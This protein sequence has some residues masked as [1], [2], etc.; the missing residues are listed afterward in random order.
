AREAGDARVLPYVLRDYFHATW[1]ADTLANRRRCASEMAE[2]AERIDDPLARIWALDRSVHVAIEAGRMG[3]AEEA[4][5]QLLALTEE[6]GQP[7]L[8]WHA[9][10]FASGLA[11]QRGALAEAGRL[12]EEAAKLGERAGE[13][14][15][16]MIYFGQLCAIRVA[17][18]RA[19][20]IVGILEGATEANPGI[21]GFEAALAAV[22]CDVERDAEAAPRLERAAQAGFADVPRDQVYLTA[23]ALWARTAADVGSQ[24]AAGPLYELIEPWRD[25]LVWNGASGYGSA[26]AYLGMLASTLGS[27][28]RAHEHFRLAS[29]VHERE[30]VKGWEAQNL[31]Y[32]A[33]SQLASGAAREGRETADRARALARENGYG[34]SAHQAE[35]LLQA[36]PAA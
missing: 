15:T 16:A 20:E 24:R 27:H 10:Y 2:L 28:E 5:K 14:D 32:W 31:C 18:G 12:A 21:P 17:E 13:P 34:F 1:S 4:L 6:L 23:L 35:A 3:E 7:G 8:R 29:R 19:E 25:Q 22:L 36:T 33:R 11:Q 30:A 26:E 9:T